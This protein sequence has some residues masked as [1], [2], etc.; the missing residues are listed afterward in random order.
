MSTI[1]VTGAT[2]FVGYHLIIAALRQ[3]HTVRA[4][5]RNNA[6]ADRLKADPVI[7]KVSSKLSFVEVPDYAAAGAY[8]EAM[9]DVTHFIHVASPLASPS[10]DPAN[11][12]YGVMMRNTESILSTAMKTPSIQK[13]VLTSTGLACIPFPAPDGYRSTAENRVPN[14]PPPYDHYFYAYAAGKTNSLNYALSFL[15]NNKPSFEFAVVYPGFIFGHDGRADASEKMFH[16]TNALLLGTVLGKKS[17]FPLANGF[18]HV[19]DIVKVHLDVLKPGMTGHFGAMINTL[20]N[21]TWSIVQRH[22]PKAVQAGILTQGDQPSAVTHF[23]SSKTEKRLGFT[24]KSFEEIVVDT[25]GQ[26]LDLLDVERA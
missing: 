19:D 9:R 5:V 3:G 10:P 2:G 23:D 6:Q 16:S 18:S 11:D 14:L 21:D 15:E 26:Y 7:A 25:V 13:V 12:I 20:W 4:S 1:L 8:D 22:Y 24:L 17:D